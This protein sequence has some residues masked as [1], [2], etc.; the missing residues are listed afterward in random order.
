MAIVQNRGEFMISFPVAVISLM[1][2]LVLKAAV[3]GRVK[4]CISVLGLEN[5]PELD[6]SSG[7]RGWYKEVC[8]ELIAELP[9]ITSADPFPFIYRTRLSSYLQLTL[10]TKIL[11]KPGERRRSLETF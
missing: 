6:A 5:P 8:F 7:N 11:V 4:A 1:L 2:S 9:F 3:R 10:S